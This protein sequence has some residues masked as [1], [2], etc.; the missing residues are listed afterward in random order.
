MASYA[1]GSTEAHL[2]DLCKQ[3]IESVSELDWTTY[4]KLCADD[5]TCFEPESEG[6]LVEGLPFHQYYFKLLG[7][8]VADGKWSAPTTTLV[9]P[10]VR[11]RRRRRRRGD[12]RAAVG[13]LCLDHLTLNA[14]PKKNKKRCACWAPTRPSSRSCGCSKSSRRARR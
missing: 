11:A 2:I 10:K 5:L 13:A 9:S 4:A 6:H 14:Q 3:L 12:D 1:P 8:W 7:E